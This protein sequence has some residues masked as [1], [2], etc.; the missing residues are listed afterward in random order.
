VRPRTATSYPRSS[1]AEGRATRGRDPSAVAVAGSE[2][3][4]A[5]SSPPS[6]PL[7]LGDGINAVNPRGLGGQSPPPPPQLADHHAVALYFKRLPVPFSLTRSAAQARKTKAPR[8]RV[9]VVTATLDGRPFP[10]AP[11]A[12]YYILAGRTMTV[13][14]ITSATGTLAFLV[15]LDRKI[16]IE[17]RSPYDFHLVDSGSDP[18]V[19]LQV[20]MAYYSNSPEEDVRSSSHPMEELSTNLPPISGSN[21]PR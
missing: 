5:T 11:I 20:E 12:V 14:A 18:S 13:S 8:N 10:G 6:L 17:G 16:S 7:L 21:P 1:R 15:P 9:I 2:S 4:A 3:R 19:P